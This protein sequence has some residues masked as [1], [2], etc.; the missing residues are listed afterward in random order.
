MDPKISCASELSFK[1]E[2]SVTA[3]DRLVRPRSRSSRRSSSLVTICVLVALRGRCCA[4]WERYNFDRRSCRHHFDE[5][6][7]LP[8]NASFRA[9]SVFNFAHGGGDAVLGS[10]RFLDVCKN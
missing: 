10:F 1:T 9:L 5:R 7:V 4:R 6:G 2:F 8:S 3:S